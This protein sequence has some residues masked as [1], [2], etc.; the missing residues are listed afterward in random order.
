MITELCHNAKSA[1]L[2]VL[3]INS[4]VCIKE[5]DK[6]EYLKNPAVRMNLEI[7]SS[8]K[9]IAYRNLE[10][11]NTGSR[12]YVIPNKAYDDEMGLLMEYAKPEFLTKYEIL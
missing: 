6:E 7:P 3:D 5:D 11:L 4:A 9:S 1:L 8:Y 2:D 10:Q 12:P